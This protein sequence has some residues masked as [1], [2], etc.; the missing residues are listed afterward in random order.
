M[1]KQLPPEDLVK[2]FALGKAADVARRYPDA[3]VVGADTIVVFGG[4]IQGKP[5]TAEKAREVL[6]SYSGQCVSVITGVAVISADEQKVKAFTSQVCFRNLLEKEID[7]YIATGEPLDK[8]G[9]FAVQGEGA[10]L[11]E[12]IE[13][14]FDNVVGLPV[15]EVKR[16]L[17]V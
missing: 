5:Q 2:E 12:K 16:M 4:K 10:K 1:T 8:A 13:G 9:A 7:D 15:D 11:V 14:S 3:V 6:K 17:P